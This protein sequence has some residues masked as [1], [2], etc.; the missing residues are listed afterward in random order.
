MPP[1]LNTKNVTDSA[2]LASAISAAMPG[3]CIV[4]A[5]GNYAFSTVTAKGTADHPIVIEAANTLKAVVPTGNLVLSDSAYVFVLGLTWP[6]T[7]TISLDNCDHCRFARSRIMRQ[8]TGADV[9]WVSVGGT[10]TYCRV[11][12]NDFG[13]QNTVS[14]M[15]QLAGVTGQ[16]VQYTEIDHNYFHDVHYNGGNG[17]ESIRA[18][19]SGWTFSS[20]HTVIEF[21]LFV[22]DANDPEI[23][24][25]KSSDNTVRH[26]TV[27]TSAGHISQR[28][29]NRN[30]YY[31][32]YI[33]GGG[34]AGS[35]GIRA[36]GGL[37]KF[38]NNYIDGV[39]QFGILLEG[40]ESTD[41][42][43][44]LTDHKEG[45]DDTVAFN[46]V[47]A[48]GI[49]LGGAHPLGPLRTTVAYNVVKGSIAEMGGSMGTTYLGNFV[50]GTGGGT[51]ANR[52]DPKLVMMGELFLP[53]PGSPVLGAATMASQFP[54]V[55]EDIGGAPRG[56]PPAVGASELPMG[57][58]LYGPLTAADVGP[59]AP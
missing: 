55:T 29:G 17:W 52:A 47:L 33:F 25:V 45:Y 57:S 8:E 58:P 14:N 15:I 23:I 30:Q 44:Q 50:S 5:D 37:H 36:F 21:N 59:V 54:F 28:H 27:R 38:F 1:C 46:T 16:I 19:L 51:D 10:S 53:G 2:S 20:S 43:G 13:P 9:E 32:N 39:S 42:T 26:N 48:G 11:D 12:H 3:D 40:G 41:T 31:G 7:G 35:A 22:N 18:G 24:S 34:V 4:M 49:T 6:G 56:T